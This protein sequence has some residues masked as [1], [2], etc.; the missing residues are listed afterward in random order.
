MGQPLN[1]NAAADEITA[2][3]RCPDK[4]RTLLDV[5]RII[6]SHENLSELLHDLAGELH[7]LLSFCYL[8]IVLHDPA[9]NVMRLHTLETPAPKLQPGMEFAMDES[10]SAWVWQHQQPLIIGDSEQYPRFR[11]SMKR[12]LSHGVRSICSVP[13]TSARRR[14]GA[15]NFGAARV[16]AYSPA[17]LEV[18]LLVASQVATAIDNALSYEEARA[19]QQQV[20]HER[21]RLRLLLE[22][23]NSVVSNLEFEELFRAISGTLRQVMECDSVNV[24]LPD[25]E[26][27]DFQVYMVDFPDGRG[28][29]REQLRIPMQGSGS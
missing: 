12:F 3:T 13:L 26:R 14:L 8:S 25:L 10:P 20:A 16:D 21:D 22:V 2:F 4:W 28:L 24:S 7:G 11:W 18:P 6:V 1:M 23:N 15:M 19:L 29:M 17:E 9:R 27:N 5:S